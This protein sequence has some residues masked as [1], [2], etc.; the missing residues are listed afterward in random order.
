MTVFTFALTERFA[1]TRLTGRFDFRRSCFFLFAFFA[2]RVTTLAG[3]DLIDDVPGLFGFDV[4][5]TGAR[6]SLLKQRPES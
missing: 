2:C 3:F 1:L 6:L 5:D 4:A